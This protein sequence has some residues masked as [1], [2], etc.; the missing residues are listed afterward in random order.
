MGVK[1]MIIGSFVLSATLCM[2]AAGAD[3]KHIDVNG[4]TLTYAE[5]GQGVPVVLVHGSLEAGG[6]PARWYR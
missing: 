3:M 2:S 4:T 6:I 1:T 5:Q